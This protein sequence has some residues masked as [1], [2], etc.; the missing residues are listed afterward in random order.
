MQVPGFSIIEEIYRGRTRV[1]YRGRRERDG[2]P[3]I[4]KTFGE[5][6]PASVASA[7]LRREY[8]LIKD[9]DVPGVVRAYGLAVQGDGPV[10]RLEDAGGEGLKTLITA[11][12]IEL[13]A[14]LRLGVR[15]AETIGAIHQ[16]DIIHK[17]INLNNILINID[18]GRST[19]IV[20]GMLLRLPF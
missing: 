3:V 9:L 14:F 6:I 1:V 18:T 8:D 20:F 17:V 12:G 5:G 16:C 11:G 19:L 4:L 2:V 10:L 15:L 13:A 7:S